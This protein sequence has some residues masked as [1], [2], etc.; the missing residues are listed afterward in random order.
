MKT[1]EQRRDEAAERE[2]VLSHGSDEENHY[3]KSWYKEGWNDCLA[4]MIQHP[5]EGVVRAEAFLKRICLE[6]PFPYRNWAKEALEI[7]IEANIER[8]LEATEL[9][10]KCEACGSE[11]VAIARDMLSTRQCCRCHRN[12]LPTEAGKP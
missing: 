11:E 1:P 6:A 10:E 9:K 12:W 2:C 7:L 4:D 8:A 5:P 3:R